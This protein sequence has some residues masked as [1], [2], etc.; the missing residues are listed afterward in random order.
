MERVLKDKISNTLFLLVFFMI[1]PCLAS[2]SWGQKEGSISIIQHQAIDDL[3]A[4][5]R[6]DRASENTIS[7]WRIQIFFDSGNNSKSKAYSVKSNFV[8]LYP[9]VDA[10]I[11]YK[12]PNYKVRVGDF[13]TR[14]DAERFKQEIL[15]VYENAFIVKDDINLPPLK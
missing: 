4:K 3:M 2:V 15:S 14:L 11:T 9:E 10:Y 8:T 1:T 5:Q 12:E 13:R 7:G 6:I